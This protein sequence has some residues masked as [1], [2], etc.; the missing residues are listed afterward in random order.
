MLPQVAVDIDRGHLAMLDGAD[1][2]V[3]AADDAIATGPDTVERGLWPSS[4]T[5]R[6]FSI[7]E[8]HSMPSICWP[9]ALNTMSA[10]RT[11]FAGRRFRTRHPSHDRRRVCVWAAP[12]DESSRRSFAPAPART[13]WRSFVPGRVGTPCAPA[14]AQR[15][16]LHGDVDGRHA[17]ADDDDV[18]PIGSVLLSSAW[19]SFAM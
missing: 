10:Y 18:L 7:V 4:T 9:M 6:P 19:R 5:M 17:A 8:R 11:N 16:A 15:L 1:R 14:R 13:H 2:E 12:D 3:V